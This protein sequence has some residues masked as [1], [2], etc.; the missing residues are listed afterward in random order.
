M[1][2]NAFEPAVDSNRDGDKV[3][4]FCS[5]RGRR[6]GRAVKVWCRYL[7]GLYGSAR[8]VGKLKPERC[9]NPEGHREVRPA[10]SSDEVMET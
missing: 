6:A 9:R 3:S 5:H 8:A 7:G 4:H 10:H 2:V 1:G